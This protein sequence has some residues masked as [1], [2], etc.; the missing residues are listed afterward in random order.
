MLLNSLP[1]WLF[2]PSENSHRE[3]TDLGTDW[4]EGNPSS[5]YNSSVFT[6]EK[7]MLIK[8]VHILLMDGI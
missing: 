1:C 4:K 6:P 5:F 2:V 3:L 8:L 7:E